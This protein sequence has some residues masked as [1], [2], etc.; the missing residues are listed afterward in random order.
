MALAV[1][2]IRNWEQIAL[3]CQQQDYY[4]IKAAAKDPVVIKEENET[5]LAL[6]Y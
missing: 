5:M 2:K 4:K 6:V 3:S 1:I